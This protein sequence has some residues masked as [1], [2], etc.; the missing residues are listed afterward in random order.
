M[1]VP[2]LL[3]LA[4]CLAAGAPCH[5]QTALRWK[6][7]PGETLHYQ[8]T[9]N[10]NTLRRTADG[11]IKESLLRVTEMSMGVDQVDPDGTAT[12]TL[13]IDRI[14]YRKQ[15]PAGDVEHDSATEARQKLPAS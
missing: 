8:R 2:A 5:A 15:S 7:A 4:A 14:R 10:Q 1:R 13:L 6:L 11:E 3:A 12:V 9:H